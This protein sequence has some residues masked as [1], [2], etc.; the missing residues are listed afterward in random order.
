MSEQTNTLGHTSTADGDA[1]A[2]VS[3]SRQKWRWMSDKDVASLDA[4][5]HARAMFVHMGATFTKTQELDVIGSGGIEY[6]Q[7]T[8][9]ELSVPFLND[10][11]AIVLT[12]MDLLAVVGGNEV[13]NPFMVTEVYVNEGAWRLASMSFTRLLTPQ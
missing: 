2:V 12:R 8:V 7:T 1:A 3:L 9:H 6:K 11:T 10:R 5:F 4:L 13:T